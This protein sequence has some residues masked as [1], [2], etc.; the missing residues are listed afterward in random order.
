MTNG[1]CNVLFL[2]A[3]DSARGMIAEAVLN[4]WGRGKFQAFSAEAEP[5][6]DVGRPA[7]EFLTAINLPTAGLRNRSWQEFT[8]PE[9]PAMDFVI[10]FDDSSREL[11]ESLSGHA[12]IARWRITDPMATRAEDA[13]ERKNAFR[14][15]FRELENRIKL[16]VLLRHPALERK[17]Q[18]S[19]ESRL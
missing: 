5:L 10:C 9:S 8:T 3:R 12:M 14:R 15:A 7:L 6:Q 11:A 13:T 16:F 18:V 17:S 1:V 2:S 4:H 19:Q